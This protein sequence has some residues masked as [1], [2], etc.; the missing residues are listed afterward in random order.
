VNEPVSKMLSCDSRL[1]LCTF[2]LLVCPT[3]PCR[4][5]W[6]GHLRASVS[7]RSGGSFERGCARANEPV[8]K[9]LSCDPRLA[10]CTFVQLIYLVLPCGFLSVVRAPM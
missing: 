6:V 4:F 5:V 7:T 1:A 2:V 10:L 3:V 9:M 8:S